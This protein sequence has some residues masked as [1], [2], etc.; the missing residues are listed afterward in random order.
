MIY[1]TN[2][3]HNKLARV[4]GQNNYVCETA[5]VLG[6]NRNSLRTDFV[7]RH[8]SQ[9]AKLRKQANVANPYYA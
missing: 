4:N 9:N 6:N 2:H 7:D 1:C 3:L 8:F 5:S